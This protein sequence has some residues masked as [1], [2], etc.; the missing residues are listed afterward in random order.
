MR[1]FY[2]SKILA[3]ILSVCL[4]LTMLAACG[5]PADTPK[6]PADNNNQVIDPVDYAASISFNKN[7]STRKA[8]VTVKTYVDG[9]TTHFH[10]PESVM[11][12]GVLK[13]RYLAVNTPESTGKIEEYGK[14]AANFT[15]EKL[16]SA[17]SIYIESDT[18]NWDADSTGGRY[19]VW[20]WYKTAEMT[21]YRNLN[22]ELLQEGLAIASSSANNR[23]GSVCMSAIDQAKAM[24]LNVYSGQ[25]DPDFY[26]GDAVELTLKELRSNIDAYNGMK[27]AFE[28][29][30][31][32]NHE[33]FYGVGVHPVIAVFTAHE[34]HPTNKECKFINFEND[35]Y[36]V[37][38]HIGLL[39]TD[40]AKDKKQHLL[41]VWFDK[42][43]TDT[44]FCVKSTVKSTDEWLHSFYYF[45]DEIPTDSDFDKTIGD[46]LSF[47]FSM[48]MQGR[49]YLFEEDDE[50]V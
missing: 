2:K 37:A 1:F 4:L 5:E 12:T 36:K 15:K 40:S 47:E 45:N 34:K 3:V 11:E 14:K 6:D 46:Y 29:V 7:S 43:E 18:S 31:T 10:V 32:L 8:E 19:L 20:V 27:V 49:E 42:V 41:D 28:G 17:E 16:K 30:I 25:K 22:I 21:E 48:I 9:D 26:Y 50:N 35:G 38:P 33:T 23:Y 24:K 39:E 13:A 44:K